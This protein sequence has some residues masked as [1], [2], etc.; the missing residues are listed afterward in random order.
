MPGIYSGVSCN[1]QD[2]YGAAWVVWVHTK[3][4]E[5]CVCPLFAGSL[6]RSEDK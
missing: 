3:V 6:S 2:V 5:S 4:D 1:C